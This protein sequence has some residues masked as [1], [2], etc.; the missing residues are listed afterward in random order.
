MEPSDIVG[1]IRK[2][3]DELIGSKKWQERK[4]AVDSLLTIVES[5]PRVAI[6][7]DLQEVLMA[8]I[9]VLEKDIN[10]NVCSVSAKVLSKLATRMRTDFATVVPKIMAIAFDKLKEK[11][12][13]LRN[14]LIELCDAA[15]VTASLE[16]YSEAVCFGLTRPNPQSRA[17]TAQFAARLLSRHDSST[18]S[19]EAVKQIVPD[20][21]KCSSD[22]DGDV[23]ESA[24]RAMAAVQRCVGE[25]AARR[26]FGE[27]SEDKIKMAKIMEYYD[28]IRKEFGE[29]AAPEIVRLHGSTQSK[30]K[31][32]IASSGS[33]RPVTSSAPRKASATARAHVRATTTPI[34]RPSSTLSDIT[35]R[36][37]TTAPKR[38]NVVKCPSQQSQRSELIRAPLGTR[39][40]QQSAPRRLSAP[41]KLAAVPLTT[42]RSSV[43]PIFAP[44]V[45]RSS[46]TNHLTNNVTNNVGK[47]ALGPVKVTGNRD[48]P[49]S[50]GN[51]AGS[52]PVRTNSALPRSNSGLRPP[53]AIARIAGTGIPRLSRP[54]SPAT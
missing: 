30:P 36:I 4:E 43:R 35:K 3:F 49:I 27:V 6:S 21:V 26:L 16:C 44:N 12:A 42:N 25:A 40:M 20:I 46:T 19:V 47:I 53:T 38:P 18:V 13:V 51:A 54:S 34:V 22:A 48:T 15:S 41:T 10:I 1:K 11:K 45:V 29:K 14:E 8:L 32:R 28:T 9:K 23:R 50:N 2:D 5:A 37:P 39:S 17:Q 33:T 52:I 24:F 31:P 7:P